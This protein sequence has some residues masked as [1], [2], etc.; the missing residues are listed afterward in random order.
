MVKYLNAKVNSSENVGCECGL[1]ISPYCSYLHG[2]TRMP[3]SHIAVVLSYQQTLILL[4]Q[5]FRVP[6]KS[7]ENCLSF[8]LIIFFSLKFRHD[9]NWKLICCNRD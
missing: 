9:K 1:W 7:I 3:T 2:T 4:K 8:S 5:L 6:W